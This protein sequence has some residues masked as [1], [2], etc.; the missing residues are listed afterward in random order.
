MDTVDNLYSLRTL[1]YLGHY[2]LAI[3]ESK[4]ISRSLNQA[5][6]VERDEFVLRSKIGL[7]HYSSVISS[8]SP[9][10]PPSHIAISLLAS[11]LSSPS[12]EL[13][14]QA[15]QLAAD[16]QSSTTISLIAGMLHLNAGDVKS[17]LRM[18]HQGLTL[19]HLSLSVQIYLR[20]DRLDLAE[21]SL[22]LMLQADEDS[23]L[24]QLSSAWVSIKAGGSRSEEG[25]YAL[26]TLGEQYGPSVMLLNALSGARITLGELD[27]AEGNLA[28]AAL[29]AEEL[30]RDNVS[31]GDRAD[32]LVNLAN[33]RAR[34]GKAGEVMERLKME[35]VN[36]PIVQGLTTVEGAIDR[37]KGGFS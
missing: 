4:T 28:D 23:T 27:K 9:S 6:K 30:G 13:L 5:Q 8:V 26:T 17:A 2:S 12:P 36:H 34:K 15:N 11:Y 29:L 25:V 33:V 20:M 22:N 21:K 24:S 31:E 14:S 1:F 32:T 35:H 7:G 19:E 16:N 10:S 3:D 18:V 37:V